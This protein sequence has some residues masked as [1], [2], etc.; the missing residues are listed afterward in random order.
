MHRLRDH[1]PD[2]FIPARAGNTPRRPPG[3]SPSTVH[4]RTGRGNTSA[5]LPAPGH[6]DGSSLPRRGTLTAVAAD[7]L[8]QRF[9]PARAGNTMP[10]STASSVRSDHPAR[11]G[12]TGESFTTKATTSVHPRTG[13]GTP[14]IHSAILSE[15]RFIPHGGDTLVHRL[16]DHVPDR[17]IPARAGNTP[18][19]PPGRNP[20]LLVPVHPRTGGEHLVHRLPADH[21]S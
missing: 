11:S 15:C 16:R 12:N 1:V 4:P 21:A 8:A 10:A 13:L 9:I 18:R 3:R 2:R 14:G 19:R 6:H 20:S 17:F 7:G 5:S